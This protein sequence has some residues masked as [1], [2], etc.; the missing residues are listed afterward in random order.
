MVCGLVAADFEGKGQEHMATATDDALVT[1]FAATGRQAWAVY[2][3]S[4]PWSLCRLPRTESVL[5]VGCAD[6]ALLLHATGK[7][8]EPS[9][10]R[11]PPDPYSHDR[12]RFRPS[13]LNAPSVSYIEKSRPR[14][15][16]AGMFISNPS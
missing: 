15:P 9:W 5:A 14:R 2:L 12:R 4:S 16:P 3:S 7:P 6:G 13:L 1:A 10:A 11:R 8:Q